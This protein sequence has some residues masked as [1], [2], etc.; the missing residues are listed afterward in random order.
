MRQAA[1]RIAIFAAISLGTMSIPAMADHLYGTLAKID[2]A[3]AFV[4]G[5]REESAPF[6]ALGK[7]G[8]PE[9]Y[10]IDLC[11]KV[12]EAVKRELK[13]SDLAVRFVPVTSKNRI[14]KVIDGTV[15]IECGSTTHT[16]ERREKVEFSYFIFLT[17]TRLLVGSN[18]T[19]TAIRDLQGK[20]IAVTKGTTNEAQVRRIIDLLKDKITV[21][22]VGDHAEGLAMVRDGKVDAFALDEIL[23]YGLIRQS[24]HPADFKIVGD[25]LT[26][27]PYALMMRRDDSQ[28]RLL[29]DR[30]LSDLFYMR[31]LPKIYDKW[32][33]PVG[34][35]MSDALKSAMTIQMHVN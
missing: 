34:V 15:D 30:T 16:L 14:D 24:G 25:F 17:G 26:Y 28:F 13:K 32:F 29:V 8:K 27:D 4:I 1:I 12:V 20:R 11:L 2:K 18:S 3:G 33:T 7:D 21:V 31:E 5:Y 10:S 23:L 19:V 6:S 35:A 22:T 9:G